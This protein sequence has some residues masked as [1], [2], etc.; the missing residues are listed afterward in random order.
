MITCRRA[1]ITLPPLSYVMQTII[2]VSI[3]LAIYSL[4]GLVL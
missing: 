3:A 1:P 4:L 2:R